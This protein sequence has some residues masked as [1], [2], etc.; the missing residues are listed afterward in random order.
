MKEIIEEVKNEITKDERARVKSAVRAKLDRQ[1]EIEKQIEKLQKEQDSIDNFLKK[2]EDGNY[3]DIPQYHSNRYGVV[4]STTNEL[5]T[6]GFMGNSING[7]ITL[8]GR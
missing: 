1:A 3:E 6:T 8:T 2:V 5:T 4:T 7:S